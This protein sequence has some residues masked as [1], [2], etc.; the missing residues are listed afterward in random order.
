MPDPGKNMLEQLCV[1]R[2][3]LSTV[4]EKVADI[5]HHVIQLRTKHADDEAHMYRRLRDYDLRFERIEKRLSLRGE[6]ID[7]ALDRVRPAPAPIQSVR[8][9][10]PCREAA[11]PSPPTSPKVP[12]VTPS[13][14]GN[15]AGKPEWKL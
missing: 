6:A 11:G 14:H 15:S 4:K 10:E 13:P 3:D 5:D 1:I 12:V 9:P 8:F 2:A 7:G